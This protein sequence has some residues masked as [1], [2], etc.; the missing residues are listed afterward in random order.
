[1]LAAEDGGEIEVIDLRS[2]RPWDEEAVL[3]S[4]ELTGRVLVLHEAPVTGGFGAEIAA[5]VAERAFAHLDAPVA[6]LGSL[7]VPIP[8]KLEDVTSA[9]GRLLPTLRRLLAY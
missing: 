1:M 5:V 8:F 3:G 7:D 4:V 9:K 2:L 6:R